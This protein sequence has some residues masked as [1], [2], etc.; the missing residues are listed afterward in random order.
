MNVAE[1]I[2]TVFPTVS[3]NA[4]RSLLIAGL[5]MFREQ[6]FHGASTR[7]IAKEA[8]V[9]DAALYV[10]YPSKNALLL[11]IALAGHSAVL[12]AVKEAVVSAPDDPRSRVLAFVRAA[13][14]WHAE[15]S[16]LARV[17]QY[18][19][20]ALEE[21]GRSAIVALRREYSDLLRRE[22][23]AGVSSGDFHIDD[24][25]MTLVALLSMSIDVA[26]WYGQRW[27]PDPSDLGAGYAGLSNRILGVGAVRP[28]RRPR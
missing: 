5:S 22:I 9:S 13:T 8:G 28:K 10:H 20:H 14:Q 21:P 3:T 26:R 4:H 17:V 23:K 27:S 7:G 18:E 2:D 6:G 19:L 11:E 25:E 12:D 1:E 15:H 16:A 24:L